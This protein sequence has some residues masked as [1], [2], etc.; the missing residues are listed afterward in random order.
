MLSRRLCSTVAFVSVCAA[1]VA[2]GQN[3]DIPADLSRKVTAKLIGG[4][5]VNFMP[6]AISITFGQVT[7]TDI[8]T[9][10]TTTASQSPVYFINCSSKPAK[11]GQATLSFTQSHSVSTS[12][13]SSL[14]NGRSTSFGISILGMSTGA[15]FNTS[16]TDTRGASSDSSFSTTTTIQTPEIDIPAKSV[17]PVALM[18]AT[19]TQQKS[20]SAPVVVDTKYVD[21]VFGNPIPAASTILSIADRTYTFT[22]TITNAYTSQG[23]VVL[24]DAQPASASACSNGAVPTAQAAFMKK[25]QAH[26]VPKGQPRII[27]TWKPKK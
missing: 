8:G 3:V 26:V 7:L 25:V 22:G 9:P 13:S 20:F 18:I 21:P 5:T 27:A 12:Y 11:H 24:Y 1:T 10:T 2:Q 17:V 4:E 23:D 16:V 15:S 19:V 6:A 14:T